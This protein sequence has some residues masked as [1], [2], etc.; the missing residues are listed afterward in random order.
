MLMIYL[1]LV[2]KINVSVKDTQ[3][4]FFNYKIK[5]VLIVFFLL[6]IDT[7]LCIGTI[8]KNIIMRVVIIYYYIVMM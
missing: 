3:N 6:L 1:I 2:Y 4:I 8:K 5:F 7:H